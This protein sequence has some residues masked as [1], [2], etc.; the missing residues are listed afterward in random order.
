MRVKELTPPED[1]S[2]V[3]YKIKCRC[4]DY[5][6][7][8]SGRSANTRLKEHKAA[9]RLANF[10][11]SAVAEHAWKDGHVIVWDHVE[12]LDTATDERQR[13]VKEAIYIKMAPPGM[14]INRD[15]GFDLSPLW[16]S[17]VQKL[18]KP[19]C[20]GREENPRTLRPGRMLYPTPPSTPPP[21]H[22]RPTP[23]IK[24][25]RMARTSHAEQDRVPTC[26]ALA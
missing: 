11:R 2:G 13:R 20:N 9:C 16:L 15:E 12:I 14:R 26:Q 24:M 21:N 3:V 1:R 23:N 10:D 4:G 5:Y 25:R 18:Q 17:G 22:R 7:G 6:I 8:E 19:R